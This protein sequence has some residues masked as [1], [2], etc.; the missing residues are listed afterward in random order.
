MQYSG[1]TGHDCIIP[2]HSGNPMDCSLPDPLSVGFSRREYW[3][4][5]PC[6]PPGDLSHPG[7]E[8]AS[9]VSCIGGQILYH[10]TTWESQLWTR[11]SKSVCWRQESWRG[12]SVYH[13]ICLKHLIK[14]RVVWAWWRESFSFTLPILLAV[15]AL[16]SEAVNMPTA[17]ALLLTDCYSPDHMSTMTPSRNS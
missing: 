3:R 16:F 12:L 1:A 9:P 11:R 15:S 5:L 14:H 7:T 4:G 8:P 13:F 17:T 10:S 2:V 6:P